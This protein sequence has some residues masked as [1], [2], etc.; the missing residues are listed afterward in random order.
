VAVRGNRKYAL[1]VHQHKEVEPAPKWRGGILCAVRGAEHSRILRL[2]VVQDG[3]DCA[4][5]GFRIA[6][7]CQCNGRVPVRWRRSA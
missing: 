5:N 1:C 7:K 4:A 2:L 6:C 3:N